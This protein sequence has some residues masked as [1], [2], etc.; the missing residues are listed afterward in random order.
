MSNYTKLTDFASKDSLP[1]GNP[2]KIAK[3]TEI[4][5]EFQAIEAAIATKAD[6]DSP[7]LTGT[8]TSPTAASGTNTTQI[9]TTAFVQTAVN[10]VSL[11][12]VY[13][14]GSVYINAASSTNPATLLGFGTWTAFGEGRVLVGVDATDTSF[15]TLGETGGSKD[16]VVV[17]HTHTGTTDSDGAHN[18]T[19]SGGSGNN[20][21]NNVTVT[22]LT[23]T[24]VS[25]ST[26][27]AHDHTFTTDS[28]GVSGTNANLQPY[29]TV[30]M[31]QR[32]A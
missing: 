10:S 30:Y 4:D 27:G 23:G 13:P 31:W 26:A 7:T 19:M 15:D 24:T 5:D 3:G 17:E 14:V 21:S 16:A 32:T 29:V 1:S 28:T 22:S 6:L 20:T 12:D 2:A 11:S 9:A 18:H 25:T 8:P